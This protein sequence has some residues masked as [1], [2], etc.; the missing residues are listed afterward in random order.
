MIVVVDRFGNTATATTATGNTEYTAQYKQYQDST[1]C[2]ND[3]FALVC[4]YTCP[5]I[6][7]VTVYTGIEEGYTGTWINNGGTAI[8]TAIR[9][10]CEY[11]QG[12]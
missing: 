7:A 10:C 3:P 1:G 4:Q 11:K 6:V 12:E 9:G 5:V 2:N 8:K